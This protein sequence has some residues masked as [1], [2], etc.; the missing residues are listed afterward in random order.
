MEAFYVSRKSNTA[1]TNLMFYHL[2]CVFSFKNKSLD[3]NM[4]NSYFTKFT[5]F[6]IWI[7]QKDKML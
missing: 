7:V 4:K 1:Y 3:D 5:N 2:F 6:I